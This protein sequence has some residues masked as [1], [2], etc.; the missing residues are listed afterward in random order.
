MNK[1]E[2]EGSREEVAQRLI[3]K[4]RTTKNTKTLIKLSAQFSKL[5]PKPVGRPKNPTLTGSMLDNLSEGERLRH[6]LVVQIENE[7]KSRG[8]WSALTR[9]DKDALLADATKSLSA[10]ERVAI[11]ALNTETVV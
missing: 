5:M 1:T 4:I 9:V 10:E 11:E 6:R 7:C 3:E 2:N 8:G